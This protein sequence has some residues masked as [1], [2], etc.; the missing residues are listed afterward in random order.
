VVDVDDHETRS[1]QDGDR[2]GKLGGRPG[3]TMRTTAGIVSQSPSEREEF[4]PPG[5]VLY[6]KGSA[7]T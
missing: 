6:R 2:V 4:T 1:G 7:A 3:L 5:D